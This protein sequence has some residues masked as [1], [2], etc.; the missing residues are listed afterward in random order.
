[1]QTA[2]NS[3]IGHEL[4]PNIPRPPRGAGTRERVM[5]WDACGR[6]LRC[7]PSNGN[8]YTAADQPRAAAVVVVDGRI[9]FVGKTPDALR[10]GPTK[11]KP[12]NR[13]VRSGGRRGPMGRPF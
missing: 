4:M 8:F 2:A 12:G 10:R 6:R 1:M 11:G 9:T 13:G 7:S 3:T 5:C